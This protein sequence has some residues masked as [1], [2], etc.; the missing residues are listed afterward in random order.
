MGRR[1][2]PAEIDYILGTTGHRKLFYIGHSMGTTMFFVM[3]SERPEYN[4]KIRAMIAFAP[5]AHFTP[6]RNRIAHFLQYAS[7]SFLEVRNLLFNHLSGYFPIV[8]A[9]YCRMTYND[10]SA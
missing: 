5:V 8:L 7:E 4:S 9:M 2:V 10:A 1:D 6:T 3:M